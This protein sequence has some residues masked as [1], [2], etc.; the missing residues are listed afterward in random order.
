MIEVMKS[1]RPRLSCKF[2]QSRHLKFLAKVRSGMVSCSTELPIRVGK[3]CSVIRSMLR[4][5]AQGSQQAGEA[6][7]RSR[8]RGPVAVPEAGV[9][10]GRACQFRLRSLVPGPRTR[11]SK[12]LLPGCSLPRQVRERGLPVLWTC[13]ETGPGPQ[14][15]RQVFGCDVSLNGAAHGSTS[16]CRRPLYCPTTNRATTAL[17]CSDQRVMPGGR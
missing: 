7:F 11:P 16:V 8:R 15:L 12:P 3:L 5:L 17:A 14:E 4:E 1:S 9:V 6:V 10:P 13:V 2:C